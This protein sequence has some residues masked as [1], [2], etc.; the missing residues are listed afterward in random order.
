VT[1][2]A[3]LHTKVTEG[4]DAVYS[5]VARENCHEMEAATSGPSS[6][7]ALID[8]VKLPASPTTKL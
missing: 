6:T 8:L 3:D 5:E 7:T 4:G 2:P 1:F